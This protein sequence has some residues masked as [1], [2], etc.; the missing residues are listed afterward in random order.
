MRIV[1]S[2]LDRDHI[3]SQASSPNTGAMNAAYT[4]RKPPV[5][6]AEEPFHMPCSVMAVSQPPSGAS[7]RRA[8]PGRLI[9]ATPKP[10]PVMQVNSGWANGDMMTRMKKVASVTEPRPDAPSTSSWPNAEPR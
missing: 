9:A 10:T 3:A 5:P 6:S 1:F 4:S 2:S 8:C 7:Q